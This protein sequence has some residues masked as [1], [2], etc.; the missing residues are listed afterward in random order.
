MSECQ[1]KLKSKMNIVII[2]NK[3]ENG[4]EQHEKEK[5]RN[6]VTKSPSKGL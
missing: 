4:D 1:K 3:C 2:I 6:G 5:R